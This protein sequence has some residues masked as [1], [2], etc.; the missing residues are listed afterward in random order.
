M[1]AELSATRENKTQI[2]KKARAKMTFVVASCLNGLCTKT[3]NNN[4]NNNNKSNKKNKQHIKT[5]KRYEIRE[6]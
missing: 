5:T 3:H 2:K 4:S 1:E 6:G